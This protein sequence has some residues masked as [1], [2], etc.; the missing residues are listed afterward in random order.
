MFAAVASGAFPGAEWIGDEGNESPAFARS[1]A[2]EG[3]AKATLS[4]TGVGY[5]E[6]RINGA[7]VGKKVLDPT[8]SDYDRRVWY[9]VYDVTPMLTNGENEIAIYLGNGLFFERT[10]SAW[11]FDKAPW[12]GFPRGIAALELEMSGGVRKRIVTDGSWRVIASPVRFNDFR[13]GEV[14]AA[15][16]PPLGAEHFASVVPRPKGELSEARH[17]GAE[18]V[19]E[20][21]PVSSWT[22]SDGATVFDFGKN[23]SGWCR[24]P[25]ARRFRRS[26]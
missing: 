14:V 20:Y 11:D 18:I 12:H 22:L 23:L 8:P 10:Q 3:V 19:A 13:E 1:F 26:W 7:K 15:K 25:S 16:A 6:A 24:I 9:S 2:A 5:C 4:V 21:A 17:P